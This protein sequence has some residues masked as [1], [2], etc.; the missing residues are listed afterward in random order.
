[1]LWYT[2][3][4]TMRA[5]SRVTAFLL[6]SMALTMI[7]R[8]GMDMAPRSANSDAAD[9][10]ARVVTLVLA[11]AISFCFVSFYVT[12]AQRRLHDETRL[13]S[14]TGLPNRL[15]LMEMAT[16]AVKQ[17]EQSKSPLAL[18]VLDVDLFKKLNDTWGHAVGDRALE[19]LGEVLRTG[20]MQVWGR[21]QVPRGWAAKSLPCCCGDERRGSHRRGGERAQ[22]R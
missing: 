3:L 2:R 1:M 19:M 11:T 16:H 13:D 10:A 22:T 9:F 5:T 20:T 14:L 6:A 12:E 4:E 17:A 21:T 7:V 18:L 8:V 15:S